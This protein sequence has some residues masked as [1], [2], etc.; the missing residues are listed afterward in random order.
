MKLALETDQAYGEIL[1]L[2][3]MERFLYRLSQ[4]EFA[5]QFVLKGALL[6]AVWGDFPRRTTM[7]IDLLGF[8][9]NSLDALETL[10]KNKRNGAP[11]AEN[12]DWRVRSPRAFGMWFMNCIIF[13]C[14]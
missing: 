12:S 4:S 3:V 9:E 14:R 8:S 6:F 2:Y 1:R 13:S 5:D 7:D 11:F 10:V